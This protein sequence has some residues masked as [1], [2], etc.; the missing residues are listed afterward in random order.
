MLG[1]LAEACDV[2]GVHIVE[3]LVFAAHAPD[4]GVGSGASGAVDGPRR[5][6]DDLFFAED[7]VA[8]LFRFAEEVHREA[9]LGEVEVAVDFG[10]AVAFG[11]A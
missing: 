10:A 3:D 5:G 4:E 9:V 8:C 2:A 6:E 7:D 11:G 1:W